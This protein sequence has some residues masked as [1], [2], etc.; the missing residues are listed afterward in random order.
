MAAE[1]GNNYA[2]KYDKQFVNDLI[3]KL[4]KWAYEDDG[5]FIS[6]FT[7]EKYKKPG[8]W[9]HDVAK[10]NPEIKTALEEAKALIC[11]KISKHCYL[12]D[13]NS[14][15]GEKMLSMHSETYRKHQQWLA[16]IAKKDLSEQEA[17][18]IV[19]AVNYAKKQDK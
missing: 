15:F 11:A 17:S 9:I 4:L 18:I 8:T 3:D 16:D 19:Q 13:R 10:S 5:I 2:Q 7:W 12:G 1:K 6:S 14:S